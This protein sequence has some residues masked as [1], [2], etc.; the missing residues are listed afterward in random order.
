MRYFSGNNSYKNKKNQSNSKNLEILSN[1]Y[2]GA[3]C[4][5]VSKVLS[6][7]L[8]IYLSHN[9]R[10]VEPVI[11]KIIG[12]DQLSFL[13]IYNIVSREVRMDLERMGIDYD[14]SRLYEILKRINGIFKHTESKQNLANLKYY[15]QKLINQNKAH[16][17]TYS[18]FH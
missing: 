15:Y 11:L 1:I 8:M 2:F 3:V 12:V 9:S 10:Y 16:K 17:D 14:Q 6:V 13:N 7:I 18:G 5:F 4:Q